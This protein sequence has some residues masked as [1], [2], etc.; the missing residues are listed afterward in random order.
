MYYSEIDDR[1]LSSGITELAGTA[2]DC[3]N[4]TF[5]GPGFSCALRITFNPSAAGTRN[6]SLTV[7]DN[8]LGVPGTK[9]TIS[10]SGT[11]TNP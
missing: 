5:L 3:T 2:R 6:G 9:Q 10:L 8:S 4:T 11:G 1:I 7:T